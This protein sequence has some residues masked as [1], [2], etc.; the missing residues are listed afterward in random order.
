[1]RS[2]IFPARIRAKVVAVTTTF[3]W[4]AIYASAQRFPMLIGWSQPTIGSAA[5]AFWV[6]TLVCV[7]ATLFGWKMLPETRGRAWEDIARSWRR[8]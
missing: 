4:M 5:G 7:F 8:H 3:L 6:F 1:M 2:E